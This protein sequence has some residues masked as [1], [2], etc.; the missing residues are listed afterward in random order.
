MKQR[1]LQNDATKDLREGIHFSSGR[2]AK[3]AALAAKPSAYSGLR[4]NF[5]GRM[6]MVS[7]IDTT[8]D[9]SCSAVD[10]QCFGQTDWMEEL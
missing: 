8:H 5:F 1:A 9:S 6:S 4:V 7:V 10:P 2:L 3:V